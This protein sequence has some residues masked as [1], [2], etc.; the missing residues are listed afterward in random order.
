MKK[1]V[2]FYESSQWDFAVSNNAESIRLVMLV[3]LNTLADKLPHFRD[4]AEIRDVEHQDYD[5]KE[6]NP[7][8]N[9]VDRTPNNN[10]IQQ[11]LL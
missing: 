2:A 4:L 11:Q 9:C 1:T 5:A 7:K 6:N 8:R 10:S 3:M